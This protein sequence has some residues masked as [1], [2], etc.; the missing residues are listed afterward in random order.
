MSKIALF[1]QE[2]KKKKKEKKERKKET[3]L[4]MKSRNLILKRNAYL[5]LAF[6]EIGL[7]Y[8]TLFH[9]VLI[10]ILVDLVPF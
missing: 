5:L 10:G 8:R 7:L 2:V 1:I 6:N 3:V 4:F 9:F